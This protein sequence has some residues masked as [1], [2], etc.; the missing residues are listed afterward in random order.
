MQC[1]MKNLH[2]LHKWASP[3]A[4][5]ADPAAAQSEKASLADGLYS[6]S[7]CISPPE[8]ERQAKNIHFISNTEWKTVTHFIEVVGNLLFF[9]P[10]MLIKTL[11]VNQKFKKIFPY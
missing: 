1:D 4:G 9:F 2:K 6:P 8:D 10:L 3:Q 7:C 11:L 5:D